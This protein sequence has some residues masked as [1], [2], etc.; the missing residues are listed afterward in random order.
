MYEVLAEVS[1]VAGDRETERLARSIQQ[2]ERA[3]AEK[4]WKLIPASARRSIQEL[5]VAKA[6]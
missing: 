5:T 2:E 4:V 3:T 1:S 6:S